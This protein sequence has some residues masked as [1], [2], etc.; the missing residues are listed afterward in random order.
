MNPIFK[1]RSLAHDV[2]VLLDGQIV[3]SIRYTIDG[4]QYVP[5][6]QKDGGEFFP[7]L[8]DCKKSLSTEAA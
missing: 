7:T 6:G 5:K 1:H 8:F 3:G 2:D 4:W